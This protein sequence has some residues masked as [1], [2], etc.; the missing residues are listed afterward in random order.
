MFWLLVRLAV[1]GV[2]YLGGR[3]GVGAVQP[4]EAWH[5]LLKIRR[6]LGMARAVCVLDLRYSG[7]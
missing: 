3:T 4:Q 7:S 2:G 5:E 6:S 1:Q